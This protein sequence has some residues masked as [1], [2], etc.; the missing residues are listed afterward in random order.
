MDSKSYAIGILFLT[1]IVLLVAQFLPVQPAVAGTAVRERDYS[2]VTTKSTAG[3]DALYV[4]DNRTG[5]IAVF[6]W[7][8][9]RRGVLIRDARP[10]SDAFTP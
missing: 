9:G 7:D 1:G 5:V 4:A 2:V 10:I 3:G 8:A 6:T